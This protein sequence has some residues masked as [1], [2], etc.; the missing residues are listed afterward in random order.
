MT[1]SAHPWQVEERSYS[2]ALKR[3]A[4]SEDDDVEVEDS[5]AEETI[6]EDIRRVVDVEVKLNMKSVR[7]FVRVVKKQKAG[8]E[9]TQLLS[10]I[11]H[12]QENFQNKLSP[13]DEAI[14]IFKATF[15][16]NLDMYEEMDFIAMLA[17]NPS[18]VNQFLTFTDAQRA[19][20]IQRKLQA[21][22]S[23]QLE[24]N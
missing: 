15:A 8:S 11:V 24:I 5:L 1:P 9:V 20:F 17:E 12:N 10:Q 4:T 22:S 18:F 21:N 3:R 13:Y 6:P 7:P 16:A 14:K 2:S 19:I 23:N